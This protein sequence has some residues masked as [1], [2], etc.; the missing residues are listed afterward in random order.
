MF[1]YKPPQLTLIPPLK[2]ASLQAAVKDS[3]D[4]ALLYHTLG[5]CYHRNNQLGDALETLTHAMKLKVRA[6]IIQ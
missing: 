5:L 2:K 4:N 3:P 6:Q 1:N